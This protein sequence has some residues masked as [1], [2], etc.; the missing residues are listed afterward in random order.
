MVPLLVIGSV[1]VGL[2]AAGILLTDVGATMG[3][4][5]SV[6]TNPLDEAGPGLMITDLHSF[7]PQSS[8]DVKLEN[9]EI[10]PLAADGDLATAWTTEPYRRRELGG[11]KEGVGLLI[12]I[13]E[14][15]PLNRIELETNTEGWVAE[16]YVGDSFADDGSDWGEPVATVDAGSD[17]VVR[18]LGRAEGRV[19]LLWLR[20]TGVTG[21][22]FRFEL[23]EVVLR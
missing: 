11:L 3:I 10:V 5:E 12:G 22:R 20:D 19:V 23:A 18:E 8:D 6:A 17:R 16:I 13:D 14:Q 15:L 2:V 21:E 1:V 4:G 9:E 7:D